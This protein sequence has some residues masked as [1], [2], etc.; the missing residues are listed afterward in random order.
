MNESTKVINAL[1]GNKSM[2]TYVIHKARHYGLNKI[3]ESAEKINNLHEPIKKNQF[4]TR[5]K[6]GL[7]RVQISR[8]IKEVRND[9]KKKMQFFK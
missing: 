8:E 4:G 6:L 2:P 3:A 7:S 9:I 5:S 1:L